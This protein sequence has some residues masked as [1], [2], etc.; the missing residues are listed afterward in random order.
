MLDSAAKK[1]G[2]PCRLIPVPRSLSS[3]CGYAAELDGMDAE[4]PGGLEE[5][6]RSLRIDWESL[7]QAGEAGCQVLRRNGSQDGADC[8]L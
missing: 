7:C 3:S 6:L 2:I 5:L 8:G 1:R 4:G